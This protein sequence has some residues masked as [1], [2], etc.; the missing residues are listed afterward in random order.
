[1]NESYDY[2]NSLKKKTILVTG[3]SRG[4][5]AELIRHL[6]ANGATVLLHYNS[7]V[8]EA[9]LLKVELGENVYTYQTDLSSTEDI[10]SFYREI[11]DN[12]VVDCVIH[13]AGIFLKSGLDSGVTDWNR[14]MN[15]T[16][17]VNLKAPALLTRLFLDHFDNHGGG[18][19][20][21]IASRAAFKGETEDHLIYAASKGGMISLSR[22]VARSQGKKNIKSFAIAPGFTCTEMAEKYIA[23]NGENAVTGDLALNKLTRPQDIAPVVCLIA[24]GH[25]DHATGT[26]ID[27]NGGSYIH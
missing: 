3:G 7:S 15:L 17:D 12:H 22:S 1:M 11:T 25:M 8:D 24:S 9:E 18:R 5:G 16:I 21:Y 27:I 13:N 14:D 10:S 4:I 26:C 6:H 2:L 20:I 23:E 19:F